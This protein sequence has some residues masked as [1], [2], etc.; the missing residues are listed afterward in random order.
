MTPTLTDE[1]VR[2][3]REHGS[4]PLYLLNSGD[5]SWYVLLPASDF[6]RVRPLLEDDFDVRE[7]YV[8]QD[9][10]AHTEGWDDPAMSVYDNEAM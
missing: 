5:Q 7:G 9:Q 8:A 6:E 3:L 2:A 1:Q 10:V 4:V